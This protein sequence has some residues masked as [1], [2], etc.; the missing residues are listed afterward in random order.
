M[1]PRKSL[2]QKRDAQPGEATSEP[3]A[4]AAG[5][6]EHAENGLV[7]L[8]RVAGNAAVGRMLSR[9]PPAPK[10]VQREADAEHTQQQSNTDF[11]ADEQDFPALGFR[12]HTTLIPPGIR[13]V[14]TQSGQPAASKLHAGDILMT[15]NGNM[16]WGAGDLS[17]ALASANDGDQITFSVFTTTAEPQN[18]AGDLAGGNTD[19]AG[20]NMGDF[21]E[22]WSQGT[23]GGGELAE[24]S[25]M[26][27]VTNE[28][29]DAFGG[30]F[31]D[32]VWAKRDPQIQR[33]PADTGL[34]NM[35][36]PRVISVTLPVNKEDLEP[37][38]RDWPKVLPE[39]TRGRGQHVTKVAGEARVTAPSVAMGHVTRGQM[40]MVKKL[41]ENRLALPANQL[42]KMVMETYK[43]D[44][45]AGYRYN[46]GGSKNV[47][48][49]GG[50]NP[51]RAEVISAIQAEIGGEGGYSAVNTYDGEGITLGRG[52]TGGALAIVMQKFFNKVPQARD[53]FLDVGVTWEGNKCRAVNFETGG[54]EVGDDAERMLQ[55]DTGFLS[56]FINIAE[57]QMGEEMARKLA[58]SQNEG[59]V[60][61]NV[62]DSVVNTWSD[63][64]TIRMAAHFIHGRGV[65][66]W[67]SFAG[68]GGNTREV[69]KV[70][71]PAIGGKISKELGGALVMTAEQTHVFASNV[72]KGKAKEGFDSPAPITIVPPLA[73]GSMTGV[74]LWHKSGNQYYKLTM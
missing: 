72:A 44:K 31:E 74:V 2:L 70:A 60:A 30:M 36:M 51:K 64:W 12:G 65:L 1:P 47:D 8:Q 15:I 67:G 21:F 56:L 27:S 14:S 32:T 13:V 22:D 9:R 68:T 53:I 4:S 69:V 20:G 37:A 62:P 42:D 66:N 45:N 41:Q 19:E 38:V 43:G 29:E 35:T 5:S 6:P 25:V 49:S 11:T 73:E 24:N 18:N 63:I 50:A 61:L 33:A 26:E 17:M 52:F 10:L 34:E 46:G 55:F 71:V 28:A 40:K 59:T 7:R 57:G 58:Q 39:V 23:E 16:L 54:I 48:P 3:K